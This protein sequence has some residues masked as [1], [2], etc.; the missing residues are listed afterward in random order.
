MQTARAD[1]DGRRLRQPGGG[2]VWVIFHGLRHH[3]CDPGTYAALFD[4]ERIVDDAGLEEIA[5]G[6]D[7]HPGTC[8]VR[9]AGSSSI[10]LVFGRPRLVRHF[11]PTLESFDEFGFS[12]AQV[13]EVPPIVLDAVP[14]GPEIEGAADHVRRRDFT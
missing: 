10:Y 4:E 5:R 1:L 8:L 12:M 11:I 6:P 3:V 2:D 9:P 7:L 14:V 13:V